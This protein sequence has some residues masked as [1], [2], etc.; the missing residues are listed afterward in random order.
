MGDISFM[1]FDIS[2]LIADDI[3]SMVLDHISSKVSDI[4]FMVTDDILSMVASSTG[5]WEVVILHCENIYLI[6]FYT[7]FEEILS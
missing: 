7:I 1:A 2:S 4:S 6:N 3:S 5:N